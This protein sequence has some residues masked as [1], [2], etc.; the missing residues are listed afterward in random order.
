M[1]TEIEKFEGGEAR[2]DLKVMASQKGKLFFSISSQLQ[3]SRV[4][5][6]EQLAEEEKISNSE[7]IGSYMFPSRK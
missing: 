7:L 6:E 2:R 3:M 4:G 5:G 1:S